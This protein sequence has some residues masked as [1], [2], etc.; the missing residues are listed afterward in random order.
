MLGKKNINEYSRKAINEYDPP[1]EPLRTQ[2]IVVL[3]LLLKNATEAIACIAYS[4]NHN[5][6]SSTSLFS[7]FVS[8]SS[9]GC[10]CD[11]KICCIGNKPHCGQIQDRGLFY[12]SGIV[13]Q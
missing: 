6:I 2:D 13:I 11:D 5:P 10:S 8:L 12:L 4:G 9:V 3:P 7:F 1:W